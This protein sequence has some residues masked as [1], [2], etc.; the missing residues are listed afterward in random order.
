M[1]GLGF[2]GVGAIASAINRLLSI[3]EKWFDDRRIRKVQAE[4]RA[5]VA[6]ENNE[7]VYRQLDSAR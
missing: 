2:G 3:I 5:K 1:S 7:A 6:A 4:E